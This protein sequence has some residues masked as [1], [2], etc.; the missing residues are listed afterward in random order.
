MCARREQWERYRDD[1]KASQVLNVVGKLVNEAEDLQ[2]TM[3]SRKRQLL[4]EN[5]LEWKSFRSYVDIVCMY[6]VSS[7][8]SLGLSGAHTSSPHRHG[9]CGRC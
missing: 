3:E 8:A 6:M 7:L 5:G 4:V 9:V 1:E 2:E